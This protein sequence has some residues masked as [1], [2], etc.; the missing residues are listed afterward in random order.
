MITIYDAPNFA[1]GP[2]RPPSAPEGTWMPDPAAL[3]DFG[4]AVSTRYS[5]GYQDLPRVRYFEVWNEPNL[6]V[7]LTPQW[8]GDAPASPDHF[9]EMLNAFHG[10]VKAVDRRAVVIAGGLAPY[11]DDLRGDRLRPL[12][13][14]RR[15]FC[16]EA[17]LDRA[18]SARRNPGST[19]SRTTRST[20]RVDRS[21]A[22][23]TR[24]MR[25]RPTSGPSGAPCVRPSMPVPS[26]APTTM[27]SGLPR[28]GGRRI[29]RTRRVSRDCANT[30]GGSSKHCSSCGRRARS[31][32]SISR[33]VTTPTPPM[34]PFPCSRGSSF[35]TAGRSRRS[36]LSLPVRDRAQDPAQARSVGQ[37]AGHR[38]ASDRKAHQAGLDEVEG[39]QSH[40]G[41]VFAGG[42]T[43]RGP[44]KLRARIGSEK[45]LIWSQRR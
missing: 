26:P 40:P 22:P 8:S 32:W 17:Q 38:S 28:F 30:R 9:R 45:S 18:P 25:R 5:G 44:A 31:L 43:F 19:S 24:T 42:L 14:L 1:E 12:R 20:P 41:Q 36:R 10:A 11:G 35:T 6:P 39:A 27:T 2:G 13:F 34:T 29:R 33:F 3:A 16:L 23:S 4:H 21:A 15:L 7:Y 37:G